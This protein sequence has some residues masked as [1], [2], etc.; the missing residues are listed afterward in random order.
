M[1]N[2][3]EQVRMGEWKTDTTFDCHLKVWIVEKGRIIHFPSRL[4]LPNLPLKCHNRGLH[5]QCPHCGP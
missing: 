1:F 3:I 2:N 4:N 5:S